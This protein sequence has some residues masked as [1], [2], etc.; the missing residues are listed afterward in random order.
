MN[1]WPRRLELK[2]RRSNTSHTTRCVGEFLV[3]FQGRWTSIYLF[4]DSQIFYEVVDIF[5]RLSY[6]LIFIMLSVGMVDIL[7]FWQTIVEFQGPKHVHFQLPGFS[8][9]RVVTFFRIST[10]LSLFLFKAKTTLLVLW[11][12]TSNI[13][14]HFAEFAGMK[15]KIISAR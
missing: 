14:P 10:S 4:F 8:Q 15:L 6:R 11:I 2:P 7:E 12:F 3:G 1:I 13:S 5:P 9:S